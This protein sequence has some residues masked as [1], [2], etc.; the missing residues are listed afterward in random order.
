MPKSATISVVGPIGTFTTIQNGKPVK[1]VGMQLVDL[2]SQI[3]RLPEDT[4]EITVRVGGMGGSVPVAKLMRDALKQLQPRIAVTTAQ[5]DDIASAHTIIF[6]AGSK[7]KAAKGVNPE[8][9]RPYGFLVH[10]PWIGNTSGDADALAAESA[11]LKLTEEELVAIYQ[12]DTGI[13][14]EAIA[15]L[16]KVES[17]FGA[18][19]AVDLKFATET[20]TATNQAAY[21]TN[22]MAQP[23][24]KDTKSFVEK[25]IAFLNGGENHVNTAPPAELLGKEMMIDGTKAVDG[26]Y[27]IVGG[28]I[29][30][31][32]E[33]PAGQPAGA[34]PAAAAPGAPAG[35]SKAPVGLTKEEIIALVKETATAQKDGSQAAPEGDAAIKQLAAL[36]NGAIDT[37]FDG[38]KKHIRTDHVP[39]GFKPENK[40]ED[41]KEFDRSFKANEHT[42]MRKDDPAKYERLFYAKYG[43]IPN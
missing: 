32:G 25:L 34:A 28:V 1:T 38:L 36:I 3:T 5:V 31:L 16:M 21:K 6:S 35:Q 27:T 39:V 29:T 43:R 8:T 19:Q 2:M 23:E 40:A 30:A 12:E 42:A 18:D 41:A 13:A 22:A 14:K 11:D 17:V 4:K 24:K 15:P 33:A 7:R 9:N 20:Y 26:V 10:N 37:K